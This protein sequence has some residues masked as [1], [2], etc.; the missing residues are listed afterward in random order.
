MAIQRNCVTLAVQRIPRHS[1]LGS[2]VVDVMTGR[3]FPGGELEL[4]Q[5]FWRYPVAL[6]AL[7]PK[8]QP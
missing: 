1:L 3:R 8:E 4:A 2:I 6:L 5:L 7:E